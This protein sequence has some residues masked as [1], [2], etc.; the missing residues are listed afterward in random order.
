LEKQH[1]KTTIHRAIAKIPYGVVFGSLPRKELNRL[2]IGKNESA[3][4]T[5]T[6]NTV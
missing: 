1:K 3:E 2:Q 6:T 4:E 5:E